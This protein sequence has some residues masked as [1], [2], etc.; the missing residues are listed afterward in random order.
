MVNI[1]GLQISPRPAYFTLPNGPGRGCITCIKSPGY[2]IIK[3]PKFRKNRVNH[4]A[5]IA[6]KT[7]R[8]FIRLFVSRHLQFHSVLKK[9]FKLN[10]FCHRLGGYPANS[11][12]VQ[13]CQVLAGDQQS[14]ILRAQGP[15]NYRFYR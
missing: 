8:F 11:F 5:A 10:C 15:L 2:A 9:T 14:F 3:M 1:A 4:Y 6:I 13:T 7:H 12:F